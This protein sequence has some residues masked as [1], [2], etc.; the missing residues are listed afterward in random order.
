M[1]RLLFSKIPIYPLV[2]FRIIFGLLM[3]AS[4]LRY[5]L[6]GWIQEQLIQPSFHFKFYGFHWVP[7][8]DETLLYA[9]FVAMLVATL[10]ISIGFLYRLFTVIFFL[11]FTYV[12]LI[13][14]TYYLNHYYFISL[15][16]F[17]MI[18][19]PANRFLAVDVALFNK[20]QTT[21]SWWTINSIKFQIGI[22]YFF[23]GLAKLNSDWLLHAQPLKMWLK[24][25]TDFPLIGFLFQY[26]WVHYAFS[27]AGALF[28]LSIVFFLFWN[29]SRKFA[30]VFVILFHLTTWMLFPRI[31]MFPFIMILLTTVFF[32]ADF[33]KKLLSILPFNHAEKSEKAVAKHKSL[34]SFF[35]LCFVVVQLLFPLRQM[36][37]PGNVHWHEQGYRFSWRVMLIEKMGYS[38]FYVKDSA[39]GN[40]AVVDN[41]QYLSDAQ[42]KQMATQPD[43]ILQFAH[44]LGKT[45]KERGFVKPKVTTETYVTLN[46]RGSRLFIDSTTNLMEVKD[47][48]AP[49]NWILPLE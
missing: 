25:Q 21:V 42:Q 33:H 40:I 8:P 35:I 48:F 6:N 17:I 10:C 24:V 39:S 9:L 37:Y 29:K 38:T 23:A 11:A 27:Y 7:E 22:V 5:W 14:V 45:Y 44:F 1:N 49:K 41:S 19:L 47:T 20:R 16:A 31:A 2:T 28:D 30:Y 12:E 43:L 4:T 18:W 32:S 15:V 26:N 3:F 46:G 36:L 13:D 34:V